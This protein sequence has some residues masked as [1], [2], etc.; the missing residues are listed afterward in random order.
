MT[1]NKF[2]VARRT[3]GTPIAKVDV[4]E[5]EFQVVNGND[6]SLHAPGLTAKTSAEAWQL[7]DDLV[8]TNPELRGHLQVL[9]SYEL[10]DAA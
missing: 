6:L 5:P 9:S 2:A 8:A 1:K 7:H 10:S 4:K 3:G